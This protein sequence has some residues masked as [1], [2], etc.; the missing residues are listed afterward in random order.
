MKKPPEKMPL[1]LQVS[2]SALDF[3]EISYAVPVGVGDEGNES[4]PIA[5]AG[6][7]ECY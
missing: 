2:G 1:R 4:G 7:E 5:G 6:Y 3:L